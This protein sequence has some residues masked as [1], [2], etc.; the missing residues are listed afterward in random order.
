KEAFN[1]IDR[2]HRDAF[3]VGSGLFQ[4][5]QIFIISNGVDTKYYANNR[6]NHFEQTF[7]W[8]DEKNNPLKALEKFTDAFLKVC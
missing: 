5:V 6:A 7:F 4:Y 3:R 2:Y 8:T 1:Q